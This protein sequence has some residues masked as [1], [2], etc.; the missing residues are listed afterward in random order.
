MQKRAQPFFC[1]PLPHS[2]H[3]SFIIIRGY[4]EDFSSVLLFTKDFLTV[5]KWLCYNKFCWRYLVCARQKMERFPSG[6][7][8][9]TVNLPSKT[10]MVRIHPSPPFIFQLRIWRNWQTRT[11]QV[12]VK[13]TSWRFKSSY[14]H[15]R[16]NPRGHVA[17]FAKRCAAFSFPRFYMCPYEHPYQ[18]ANTRRLVCELLMAVREFFIPATCRR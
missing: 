3:R 12:R 14:P 8:E 2:M 6:Q 16:G 7:R 15:Q 4:P 9:Q 10:S 13:A 1:T 18:R 17:H 11:V 5:C